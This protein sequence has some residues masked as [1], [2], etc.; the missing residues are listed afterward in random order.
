MSLSLLN[1]YGQLIYCDGAGVMGTCD[2]HGTNWTRLPWDGYDASFSWDDRYILFVDMNRTHIWIHDTITGGIENLGVYAPGIFRPVM[3]ANSSKTV[4]FQCLNASNVFVIWA[5]DYTPGSGCSNPRVLFNNAVSPAISYDGTWMAA[6]GV[7]TFSNGNTNY[8]NHHEVFTANID[9]S[10]AY[11]FTHPLQAGPDDIDA[12]LP[13][14]SPWNDRIAF[15]SGKFYNNGVS[16]MSP[17][18]Y[19]AYDI[20]HADVI[21]P[22]YGVR[23]LGTRSEMSVYA[24]RGAGFQVSTPNFWPN[25]DGVIFDYLN[26]GGSGVWAINL[27]RSESQPVTPNAYGISAQIFSS[28]SA[29]RIRNVYPAPGPDNSMTTA[30]RDALGNPPSKTL[31][32][33]TDISHHE[34]WNQDHWQQL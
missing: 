34:W 4:L 7:G 5:V 8:G 11:W 32:F 20:G 24:G 19:L 9:A 28:I 22:G 29:R 23:S 21:Y 14:I 6:A 18:T 17:S 16:P 3:V 13:A 15:Q 1:Q 33:N 10:A 30:Q 2:A 31:I 26:T 25:S 27:A 12:T